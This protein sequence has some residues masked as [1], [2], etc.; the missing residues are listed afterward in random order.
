VPVSDE[1]LSAVVPEQGVDVNV[2]KNIFAKNG[3]FDPKTEI[4]AEK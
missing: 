3:I 2:F 4:Y 1:Y